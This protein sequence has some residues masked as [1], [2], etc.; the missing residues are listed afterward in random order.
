L[1]QVPSGCPPAG[2][3]PVPILA[4]EYLDRTLESCT[5]SASGHAP[6]GTSTARRSRKPSDRQAGRSSAAT[7]VRP[8]AGH[9]AAAA[10]GAGRRTAHSGAARRVVL[11]L[12]CARQSRRTCGLFAFCR[13]RAPRT[14]NQLPS[15]QYR[16]WSPGQLG[17]RGNRGDSIGAWEL[18]DLRYFAVVAEELHFARAAQRL[19]ISQPALSQQIRRLEGELGFKLLE[20]KSRG[21]KLTA[22]GRAF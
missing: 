13:V 15:G 12:P 21:V 2:A 16:C 14:G 5:E 1:S 9:T 18:R 7:T 10:I 11:I 20:R 6:L 8:A 3:G 17:R 4:L 19:F 22:E